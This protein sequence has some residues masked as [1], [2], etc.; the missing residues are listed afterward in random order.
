MPYQVKM[1]NQP[2]RIAGSLPLTPSLLMRVCPLVRGAE[3]H[4][5]VSTVREVGARVKAGK[6]A[7][8]IPQ[9]VLPAIGRFCRKRF[10]GTAK[11]GKGVIVGYHRGQ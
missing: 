9:Y 8:A 2:A 1:P 3:E 6:I 10:T 5:L 11:R 4:R 7:V